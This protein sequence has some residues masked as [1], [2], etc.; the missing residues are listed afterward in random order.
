MVVQL[1]GFIALIFL[2]YS[3][4]KTKKESILF[5]QVISYIFYSIH[6]LLLNASSGYIISV[7]NL[8]KSL[9]LAIKERHSFLQKNYILFIMIIVYILATY[10]TYQDLYSLLPAMGAIIYT[11]MLWQGTVKE[12]NIGGIINSV[13][14]VI[15]NIHVLSYVG[16]ISDSLLI[17]INIV[18]LIRMCKDDK[19]KIKPITN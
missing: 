7:I 10:Y 12:V 9:F 18:M 2:A 19:G 5:N 13:L 15:Y 14:W 3:F 16:I 6:Y 4:T 1:L 17:I 8:L 11:S